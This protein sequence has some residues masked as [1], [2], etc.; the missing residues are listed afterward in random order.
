[1]KSNKAVITEQEVQEA[2]KKFK[3]HGGLIK[4]LPDEVV[5]SH[6]LVGSRWAVYEA[7][8]DTSSASTSESA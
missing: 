6:N 2:L 1:M 7:I 8:Q 5:P 4:K 3:Q